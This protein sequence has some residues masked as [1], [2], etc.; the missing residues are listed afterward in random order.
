MFLLAISMNA[1]VVQILQP[2][3]ESSVKINSK[4][5]IFCT[6]TLTAMGRLYLHL[7]HLDGGV[8]NLVCGRVKQRVPLAAAP[9]RRWIKEKKIQKVVHRKLLYKSKVCFWLT[10]QLW[11]GHK[12]NM[13]VQT[14][15]KTFVF[16]LFFLR[17]VAIVVIVLQ[18][19]SGTLYLCE[20]PKSLWGPGD[21]VA[22]L[23]PGGSS[24]A[25]VNQTFSVRQ[26]GGRPQWP[27]LEEALI[28][29]AGELRHTHTHTSTHNVRQDLR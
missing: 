23:Q 9:V 29:V 17:V 4:F 24:S 3:T 12:R 21:G 10:L 6:W 25:V 11:K 15:W 26:E 16:F 8:S 18:Y 2:Q 27:Q 28:G 5:S 19:L 20:V 22:L 7:V 1:D 14:C 13:W